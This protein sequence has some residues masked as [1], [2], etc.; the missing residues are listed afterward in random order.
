VQAAREEGRVTPREG[1]PDGALLEDLLARARRKGDENDA[2]KDATRIE[3]GQRRLL[4]DDVEPAARSVDE[5]IASDV[6]DDTRRQVA[7]A[8][9]R[10]AVE[11]G[12]DA[13][14]SDVVRV[15]GKGVG[16]VALLRYRVLLD[17]DTLLE[18][19]EA[20]DPFPLPRL[21]LVPERPFVDN[22]ERLVFAQRA[23]QAT[24]DTDTF[25]GDVR[26][27]A[28]GARMRE[29]TSYQRSLQRESIVEAARD[30][31]GAV[32]ALART[33]GRLLF[34]AHAHAPTPQ[35]TTTHD[36]LRGAVL[37]HEETL[38]GETAAFLPDALSRHRADHAAFVRL[39][40][41]EG[42]RLGWVAP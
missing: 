3:D 36:G 18:M 26:V 35:R 33:T 20:R 30:Q 11:H 19:K 38:L 13:R 9:T 2:L 39:L 25:L 6:D 41:E 14:V 22:A 7:R 42:P 28:V 34:S 32:H 8:F 21:Q 15:Y 24:G 40:D 4:R 31:P 10:W 27:T 5:E 16:S 37:A 29:Q 12:V 23:L 17:D 1:A